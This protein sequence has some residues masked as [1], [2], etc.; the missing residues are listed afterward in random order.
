MLRFRVLFEGADQGKYPNGTPFSSSEIVMTPVLSQVF[1]A[2]ELERYMNFSTFKESLFSLASN[3][4]FQLL[5]YEYQA[6]LSDPK[7]T[8]VDRARLEDEFRKKSE[9]LKSADFALHYRR[10]ERMKTVPS[11]LLSK[12]LNDTLVEWA[13]QA[14]DYRGA[15]KYDIAVLS[16]GIL[17][18]EVIKGEDYIV[19]VDV[20]RTKIEKILSNI[21]IVSEVP[22]ATLMRSA[23]TKLSLAEVKSNLQDLLR[24]D[25]EPSISMITSAK[26][27]RNPQRS[28]VYVSDQLRQV[29]L[30]Q[31]ASQQR[32]KAI[33]EP[34][35]DY[36]SQGAGRQS[37]AAGGQAPFGGTQT[38]IPQLGESFLQQIV[39][40]STQNKDAEYRQDLTD[41]VIEEGLNVAAHEREKSYYAD[42]NRL[43]GG[44]SVSPES[45]ES[46]DLL[47]RLDRSLAVVVSSLEDINA[48]Y[49][50]LSARN[51]N[52]ATQLYSITAPF[53]ERT[54]RS[55]SG[56][57]LAMF[58]LMA[59]V[60]GLVGLVAGCLA[61][62]FYRTQL[63]P[64][65]RPAA[66]VDDFQGV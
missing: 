59:F 7:L 8:P 4:D 5:T 41:R 62:N 61:H 33:Q 52:P 46:R 18:A 38:L 23:K 48:I 20:L 15:L 63:R 26:L 36:V 6:K 19:A 66:P 14:R 3:D 49:E 25:V 34:L 29:V 10:S 11:T 47:S 31:A 45:A 54:E 57:S 27:T 39:D 58:G 40:M 42:L 17:Q 60:L 55:V 64:V 43:V 56:R 2:N 44:W 35:R 53:T 13:R 22:G 50:E 16:P 1:K 28:R 65:D 30:E 51:L 37:V 24:F 21:E 32:M 9:S 12:V